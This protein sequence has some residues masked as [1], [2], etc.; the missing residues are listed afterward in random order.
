M[1]WLKK[2][3]QFFSAEID[4]TEQI[5]IQDSTDQPAQVRDD[6]GL[7]VWDISR[8]DWNFYGDPGCDGEPDV[9]VDPEKAAV[10]DDPFNG[11]AIEIPIENF[12][13]LHT[14]A[15]DETHQVLDAYI[16]AAREKGFRRVRIIHGR[17][18]G[19]QRQIVQSYLARH[20]AVERFHTA[21]SDEGGSGAT[22]AYL[23]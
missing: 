7:S 8:T 23:K 9:D 19:I 12:I 15:P 14:F 10:Y 3:L 5:R 20:Y 1:G 18:R 2:L 16:E 22:I 11:V 21:R 17:G 4:V 6:T 13:D